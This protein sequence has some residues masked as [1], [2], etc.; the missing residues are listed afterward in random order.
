MYNKKNVKGKKGKKK[1]KRHTYMHIYMHNIYTHK[2]SYTI[3]L[4]TDFSYS[5]SS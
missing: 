1:R 4:S 2:A 3:I 5:T